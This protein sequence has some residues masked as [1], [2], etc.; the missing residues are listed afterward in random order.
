MYYLVFLPKKCVLYL[1]PPWEKGTASSLLI[2]FLQNCRFRH[3]GAS[4]LHHLAT[5]Q[6]VPKAL[7]Y[8]T[9]KD[10]AKGIAQAA[11]QNSL[12][13]EVLTFFGSM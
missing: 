1:S 3:T 6:R 4:K 8:L 5:V 12:D 9:H 7:G 11:V 10:L 2:Y 13:T